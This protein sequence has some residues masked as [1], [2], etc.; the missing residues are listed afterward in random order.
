MPSQEDCY[1]GWVDHE[2]G[3]G[4]YEKVDPEKTVEHRTR[5]GGSW[6]ALPYI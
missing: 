4:L 3:S 2:H 1:R 6:G 5:D